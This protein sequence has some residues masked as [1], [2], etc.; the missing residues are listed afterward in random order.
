MVTEFRDR[1]GLRVRVVQGGT[2][3][4]LARLRREAS[5]ASPSGREGVGCDVLWGGGAESL[6]ANADLFEPYFSPEA[7]AIPAAN[8]AP[9]GLW[10]GFT[11]LPMAIGYN[12][13]LL[14][15]DR[16]PKSWAD[17][18]DPRYKGAIAYA[19]P[20]V[21]ASSYTILRTL[22]SALVATGRMS[23]EAAEA[24][25]VRNLDGKLIPESSGVFPAVASGEYLV[26]LYHDEGARELMLSGSD[27]KIVYPADGTSAVPDAVALVKGSPHKAAA[28]RFMDFVLGA[29]VAGVMAVRFHRRSARS[30]CPTPPGQ[31][32][33]SAIR[34]VAYDIGT[35]ASDKEA[36]LARFQ[37]LREGR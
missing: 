14:P 36:T 15:E 29:D 16:V 31:I 34:L 26:G 12:S 11:L 21:S 32:P 17:L 25:F 4:M 20:A 33:L 37:A 22:G 18:L 27:L 19:D 2:G 30:D 23:R 5:E 24:A 8:K 35:A 9:D 6:T 28:R 7:S 1:T 10:T 3:E 13:R